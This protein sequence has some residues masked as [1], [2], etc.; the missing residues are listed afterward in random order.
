MKK[1]ILVSPENPKAIGPYSTAVKI[2]RFV[3]I[4]GQ[5]PIDA[6]TNEIVSGG[7]KEQTKQSLK[8]L[9]AA[10][11][12]YELDANNVVKVTIFLKNLNHFT[13]VN[14][15]Y[16]EHFKSNFPARSCVQVSKLPKDADI[17]IEAIACQ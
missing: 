17:E 1:E 3:F 9:I 5:L 6:K 13:T 16:A 15:I 14:Q 8:N 10:L 7:I 2:D 4:S 11:K 12:P